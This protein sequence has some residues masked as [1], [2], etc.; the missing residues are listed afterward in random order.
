MLLVPQT[1][2]FPIPQELPFPQGFRLQVG[3][4]DFF[5]L[6]RNVGVYLS[7]IFQKP[8]HVVIHE[9]PGD[10]RHNLWNS[11]GLDEVF[12][13]YSAHVGNYTR[14]QKSCKVRIVLVHSYLRDVFGG[15]TPGDCQGFEVTKKTFPFVDVDPKV[16]NVVR[17]NFLNF[18][19]GLRS[20]PRVG[21]CRQDPIFWVAS[22]ACPRRIFL[23]RHPV[24]SK[25]LPY[26][27]LYF[28]N[29]LI[30]SPVFDRSVLKAKS[31][32]S[33]LGCFL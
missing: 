15:A 28:V 4:D 30:R 29:V 33:A 9:I 21:R 19:K 6:A 12:P 27:S 26:L 2:V 11:L 5:H 13:A 10:A 32:A 20:E 3:L 31:F 16:S 25:R 1:Y 14:G 24:N 17:L 23:K 22:K 18:L 8:F 7:R